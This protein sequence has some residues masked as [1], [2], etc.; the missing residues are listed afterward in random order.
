MSEQESPFEP[1]KSYTECL[2]TWA[3]QNTLCGKSTD[4]R[5]NTYVPK[6]VM[7]NDTAYQ[8]RLKLTY[9]PSYLKSTISECVGK[10]FDTPNNIQAINIHPKIEPFLSDF[11]GNGNNLQIIANLLTAHIVKYGSCGGL[12]EYTN[13]EKS[14]SI[15]RPYFAITSPLE[16]IGV[17]KGIEHGNESISQLRVKTTQIEFSG[18]FGEEIYEYCYVYEL[19]D[20]GVH[21]YKYKRKQGDNEFTEDDLGFLVSETGQKM[22]QIPLVTGYASIDNK[23]NGIFRS[24]PVF[25][26]LA[27]KTLQLIN[28]DSLYANILYVSQIPLLVAKLNENSETHLSRG[29]FDVIYLEGNE[30]LGYVNTGNFKPA[31]EMSA[32]YRATLLEE[33]ETLGVSSLTNSKTQVTATTAW[34]NN[35]NVQSKLMAIAIA[36]EDVLNNIL[37]QYGQWLGIDSNNVGTVTI[38]QDFGNAK[39]MSLRSDES[40]K[41]LQQDLALGV[42]TH[43]KYLEE[44]IARGTFATD[45]DPKEEIASAEI[46]ALEKTE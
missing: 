35:V 8:I 2:P 19:E 4:I 11:D 41:V 26:T 40:L 6:T 38:N 14:N 27:D 22:V 46:D 3:E 39:T 42:I 33:I 18:R 30:D 25:S 36:I 32:Q 28:L 9:L 12:V 15:K 10:I 17:R 21:V 37:I 20:S 44:R 23:L 13:T 16:V 29:A 31:L 34:I 5:D 1:D 43:Q 7:E 45:F 24:S